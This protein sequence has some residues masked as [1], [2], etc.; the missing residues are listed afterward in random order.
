MTIGGAFEVSAIAVFQ[1]L[2]L[3]GV[4]FSVALAA[5]W[6][7]GWAGQ[8]A[9]PS[10][11]LADEA[12]PDRLELIFDNETLFDA[13]P[14]AFALLPDLNGS[15]CTLSDFVSLLSPRFPGLEEA[16]ADLPEAR[17][18]CMA[19]VDGLG[20][21]RLEWRDGLIAI[22]IEQ[23]S[24][25]AQAAMGDQ[26][27]IAA[28]ENELETLR[29][30]VQAAPFLVWR[31]EKDGRIV[32]ANNSYLELSRLCD[33]E[34]EHSV[35]PPQMV[36]KLSDD[37]ILS[38]AH[39]ASD[40]VSVSIPGQIEPRWFERHAKPLGNDIL[41]MAASIDATVAAETALRDFV[42]TL[43]KTFAH[44]RVGLA[45]FDKQRKLA[46]FN[47]ALSDLTQLRP[48]FLSMRPTLQA[49]LDQLR[50]KRMIPEPRDYRSWRQQIYELESAAKEGTYEETWPLP[51][52][53][54][55]RV[56]GRPHPDGA[57]AFLFEDKSAEI[58]L[59]RRYRTELETGQAVL[60]SIDEALAVFSPSGTLTASNA[61]YARLWGV[62]SEH[63]LASLSVVD[64]TRFWSAR[65][66]P[67]PVWG[68]LR[69]FAGA[70]GQRAEWNCEVRLLDGRGLNC[71]FAP[72]TGGGTLAGFTVGTEL[73]ATP[74]A[75][76]VA[77]GRADTTAQKQNGA[78]P[79]QAL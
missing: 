53:L 44:L 57:L 46:L 16:L 20:Q 8:R 58:S 40:R 72:L 59:T 29:A 42:Q 9:K 39:E 70:F 14:G 47:P 43:T 30:T 18:T 19:A 74:A 68:D 61:A 48:E 7:V 3:A 76:N 33:A 32:W 64:A 36:F 37:D 24:V 28:M 25:T 35:W 4:S 71:R 52:G 50:D 65:C 6:V 79:V 31:Q 27:D 41:F 5:L 78:E 22:S 15:G 69:E 13:S 34:T 55:Y 11:R 67:S 21:V 49:F 66:A 56:S 63:A 1:L 38:S 54:T 77:A 60:D 75:E 73:A 62:E 23:K 17:K 2:F 26:T 45:I 10:G 51:N 12:D